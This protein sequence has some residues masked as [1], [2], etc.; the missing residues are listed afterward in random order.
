MERSSKGVREDANI[1]R[2]TP[3][4]MG[5]LLS[6]SGEIPRTDED[7]D[8]VDMIIDSVF[9]GWEN[10][11]PSVYGSESRI[12]ETTAFFASFRHRRRCAQH[13]FVGKLSRAIDGKSHQRRIHFQSR[14]PFIDH[15]HW[16]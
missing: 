6:G 12:R 8:R 2:R 11:R 14:R 16:N 10:R 7:D 9:R 1:E 13:S 15:F 5:I 3:G 4:V